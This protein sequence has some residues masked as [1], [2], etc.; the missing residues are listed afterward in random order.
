MAE[1]EAKFLIEDPAQITQ[2]VDTLKAADTEVQPIPAVDILDRY[3]DTPDWQVLQEGWAYRWR[4]APG[5]R[6]V[7]LKSVAL[8]GGA[9]QEREEIE[10]PVTELPKKFR[11][12]PKGPVA[13]KLS[14]VR[15]KK[16]NELF[17]VRNQRPA[18]RTVQGGLRT[19]SPTRKTVTE[20]RSLG[21]GHRPGWVGRR[22]ARNDKT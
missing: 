22:A 3:L 4:D 17:Q 11:R 13:R 20:N 1:I 21:V 16:L 8:N 5:K 12:L 9:V 7:G 19:S 10:Q 15:R 6:K 2:L 14:N 18:L